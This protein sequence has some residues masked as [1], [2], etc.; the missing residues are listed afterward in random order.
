MPGSHTHCLSESPGSLTTCLSHDPEQLSQTPWGQS[1]SISEGHIWMSQLGGTH[2]YVASSTTLDCVWP[3]CP[4]DRHLAEFLGS[5]SAMAAG[6]AGRGG[7][8]GRLTTV[9]LYP[10][11]LWCPRGLRR[12]IDSSCRIWDRHT[13]IWALRRLGFLASC[14]VAVRLFVRLQWPPSILLSYSCFSSSVELNDR[15]LIWNLLLLV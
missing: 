9:S 3:K 7:E 10:V 5:L 11:F 15:V 14:W 2:S 1:P 4:W 12:V 6:E 13:W 8:A